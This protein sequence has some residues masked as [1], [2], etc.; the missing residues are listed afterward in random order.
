MSKRQQYPISPA[1]VGLLDCALINGPGTAQTRVM[2]ARSF[3]IAWTFV[4]D[5]ESLLPIETGHEYM[6]LL[7]DAEAAINRSESIVR[8]FLICAVDLTP[9]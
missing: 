4:A 6:V 1:L 3:T 2:R 5:G 8:I 9:S 7:P